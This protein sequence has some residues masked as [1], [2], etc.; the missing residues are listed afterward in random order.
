MT[1]T[2]GTI[3]S[4]VKIQMPSTRSAIRPSTIRTIPKAMPSPPSMMSRVPRP[5]MMPIARSIAPPASSVQSSSVPSR[6]HV[7][8]Q[9]SRM[10]GFSPSVARAVSVTTT[11]WR[12]TEPMTETMIGTSIERTMTSSDPAMISSRSSAA[13]WSMR[14]S[15]RTVTTPV[16]TRV[17]TIAMPCTMRALP[18]VAFGL[19]R[20]SLNGAMR[21]VPKLSGRR[22]MRPGFGGGV[23]PLGPAAPYPGC[24]YPLY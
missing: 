11:P 21:R 3:A 10:R 18:I 23:Q 14:I 12:K 4:F 19:W 1:M 24:W 20:S 22:S 2:L 16:T 7:A 8:F 13:A 9:R 6:G 15:M 5:P 17:R